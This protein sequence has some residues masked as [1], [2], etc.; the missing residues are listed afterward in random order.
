[1]EIDVFY[2]PYFTKAP[3]LRH[4]SREA[5]YIFRRKRIWLLITSTFFTQAWCGKC[6]G[7]Q[8]EIQFNY[9]NKK[10]RNH[11]PLR[12]L[13]MSDDLWSWLV[14]NFVNFNLINLRWLDQITVFRWKRIKFGRRMLSDKSCVKGLTNRPTLQFRS[15]V[16]QAKKRK[17]KIKNKKIKRYISMRCH[18][19]YIQIHPSMRRRWTSV[20]DFFKSVI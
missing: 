1:M 7:P 20:P 5:W 18:L 19:K 13:E 15:Q 8:T 9:W 12:A 17:R 10:K 11:G 14:S 4:S 2:S 3:K 6:N 16:V